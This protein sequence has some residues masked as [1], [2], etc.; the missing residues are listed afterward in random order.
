MNELKYY[1]GKF[2]I[3]FTKDKILL[4]KFELEK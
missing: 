4:D 2:E 1:K 3:A